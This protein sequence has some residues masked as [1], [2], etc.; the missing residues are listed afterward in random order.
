MA[1]C[2]LSYRAEALAIWQ[3]MSI[4][5]PD[6]MGEQAPFPVLV[7]LGGNSDD[8]TTWL[9]RTRIESYVRDTPL[10]VVFPDA[11]YGRYTDWHEHGPAYEQ[12]IIEDVLGTV[13]AYFPVRRDRGGRAIGGLSMGGYGGMKLALKYPELFCSVATHSGSYLSSREYMDHM[14]ES[15]VNFWKHHIYGPDSKG[16]D[17]DVFALAERVDRDL[18]PAIRFDCGTEDRLLPAARRLHAHMESLGIPHEYGEFPGDH[19]WSYWDIHIQEALAFHWR[20]LNPA[21]AEA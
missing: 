21:T 12:H 9:R 3:T 1:L 2:T 19:E 17:N 10:V 18:L 20:S 4:I 13:E 5:L 16:G 8:H 14:E 11:G 7:Q 6:G 15:R